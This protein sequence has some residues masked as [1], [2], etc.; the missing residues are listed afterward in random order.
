LPEWGS[1]DCLPGDEAKNVFVRILLI[2]ALVAG[3]MAVVAD[4]RV[5]ERAGL[6]GR[7]T[8]ASPGTD[9]EAGSW[10]ACHP[11][12]LEGRPDL[13]KKSC[14]SKFVRGDVEYWLCPANVVVSQA[15]RA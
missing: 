1:E 2:T 13:S 11:G 12:L 7:C 8:A 4:G 3:V 10:Q 6:V 14:V 9:D 15:P 5:I